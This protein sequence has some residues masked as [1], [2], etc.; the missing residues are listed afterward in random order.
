MTSNK[1]NMR[2]LFILFFLGLSLTILPSC[3]HDRLKTNGKKLSNEILAQEKAKN[4]GK[5][6]ELN[7]ESPESSN[8]FS[9]VLRK[10]E[11]RSVDTRRPPIK[12][13]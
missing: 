1:S 6:K 10:K 12:L 11:I 3:R 4:E 9:G 7:N 13:N 5:I 8:K 2:Q